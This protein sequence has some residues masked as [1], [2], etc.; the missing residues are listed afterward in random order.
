M[1][2]GWLVGSSSDEI[3]TVDTTVVETVAEAVKG[4]VNVEQGLAEA[5][6]LLAVIEKSTSSA[7]S[8]S[9]S[10]TSVSGSS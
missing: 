6:R 5:D 10:Q 3:E 1:P 8:S 7:S 4:V 2:L 9:S